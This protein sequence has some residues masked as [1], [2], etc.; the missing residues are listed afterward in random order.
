MTTHVQLLAAFAAGCRDDGLPGEVRADV[1]GRILDVLGNCLAAYA[2]PDADA[3]PAV[4]RAALRW[5]GTGEATT[6][7]SGHRLP[8]PSAALV[9]GT[10]A[11][12]L[13]YDDTHL[14]SVLKGCARV[15]P[16]ALAGGVAG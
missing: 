2:E 1:A 5:N 3:A 7:G 11:H 13:D 9:N 16:A 12:S 4:L 8:A 14:P 6:I 10:L 15:V